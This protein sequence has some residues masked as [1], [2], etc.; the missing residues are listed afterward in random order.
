MAAAVVGRTC[1]L[2][3]S[4]PLTTVLASSTVFEGIIISFL[5]ML[6]L[7]VADLTDEVEDDTEEEADDVIGC[8]CCC[9]GKDRKN[10]VRFCYYMNVTRERGRGKERDR[11]RQKDKQEDTDEEADEE[12]DEVIGCC[13]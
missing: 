7:G 4:G 8:C 9:Y 5:T 13:C 10:L 6:P 1:G 12:A 2:A 11:D 3:V